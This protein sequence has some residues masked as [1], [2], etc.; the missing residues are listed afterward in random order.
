MKKKI[1][2]SILAAVTMATCVCSAVACNQEKEPT[3]EVVSP[4]I[5]QEV[6]NDGEE[7]NDEGVLPNIISKT[8]IIKEVGKNKVIINGENGKEITIYVTE[9]TEIYGPD[10][11]PRAFEDL[12]VGTDITIDIDG[13]DY[14][15][16]DLK[17]EAMI[18]YISGK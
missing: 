6:K 1:I 15:N 8:G 10:G 4:T 11:A 18:I 14:T 3:N 16:E 9:E 7:I 13:E 5:N 12:T 2:A 17:F